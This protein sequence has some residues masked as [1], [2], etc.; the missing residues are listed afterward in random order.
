MTTQVKG[1]VPPGLLDIPANIRGFYNTGLR[2]GRV[3]KARHQNRAA[4]WMTDSKIVHRML[5]ERFPD[6]T[7]KKVHQNYQTC[8]CHACHDMRNYSRWFFVIQY[9][10]VLGRSDRWVQDK[11]P[12]LF[13]S[14]KE[15]SRCVQMIHFASTG[16]RL[17]GKKPTG[18]KPGRPIK[19][20][21]GLIR[22]SLPEKRL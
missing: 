10:F 17:D 3:P 9:W 19:E 18:R 7:P 20:R 5:L 2:T 1:F 14:R 8:E 13:K 21:R 15:V 6:A 22:A 4:L 16:K 12:E 11:H